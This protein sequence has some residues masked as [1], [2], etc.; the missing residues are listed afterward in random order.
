MVNENAWLLKALKEKRQKLKVTSANSFFGEHIFEKYHR[1]FGYYVISK[2]VERRPIWI[3]QFIKLHS[4]VF[5]TK[6]HTLLALKLQTKLTQKQSNKA[7]TTKFMA[8]F[9]LEN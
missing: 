1:S 3:S 4:N 7:K 6:T 5:I 2:P 9:Y 8:G